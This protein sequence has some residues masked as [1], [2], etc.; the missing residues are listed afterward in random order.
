MK[1]L[2]QGEEV[3]RVARQH[4][5]VF[6]PQ[7]AV[8]VVALAVL[9]I[10]V[11]VLPGTV[12]DRSLHDIKLLLVLIGLLV[13][14]VGLTF[15]WA[16]WRYTTFTLT[17]RRVVVSRGVLSRYMESIT[18]DRIQDVRVTQGFGARLVHSGDVEIESAGRDGSAV[19]HVIYDPVGFSNDLQHAAELH[20]T[21]QPWSAP[22]SAFTPGPGYSPP[23]GE[24]AG[25]PGPGWQQPGP[26]DR[27]RGRDGGL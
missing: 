2:L 18:L 14:A 23:S 10:I 1:Q 7:V 3:V 20:R 27:G 16:R 26:G 6:V 22:G 13:A 11:A 9:G 15:R 21:G 19:L 25:A 8:T 12:G 5:S 24:G 17:N 4:W